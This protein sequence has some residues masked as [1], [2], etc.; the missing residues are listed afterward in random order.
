MLDIPVAL[1]SSLGE[2]GW[3]TVTVQRAKRKLATSES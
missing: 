2:A 3:K 1:V